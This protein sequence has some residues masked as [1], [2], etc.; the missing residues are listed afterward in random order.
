MKIT[1]EKKKINITVSEKLWFDITKVAH[2]ENK[3]LTKK[4]V[5]ILESYLGKSE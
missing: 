5:E 1:E 2:T 3:S 4:I